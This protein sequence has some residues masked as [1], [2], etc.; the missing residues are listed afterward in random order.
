MM[1]ALGPNNVN[2]VS[3]FKVLSTAPVLNDQTM[4]TAIMSPC[5]QLAS[6]RRD[7]VAY[8]SFMHPVCRAVCVFVCAVCAALGFYLTVVRTH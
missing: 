1:E 8:T 5:A 6:C 7:A 2:I 4:Y 3:L